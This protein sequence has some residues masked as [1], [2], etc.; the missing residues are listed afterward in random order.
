MSLPKDI[1]DIKDNTAATLVE[2]RKTNELLELIV[3]TFISGSD[4][5]PEVLKSL[6]VRLKAIKETLAAGIETAKPPTHTV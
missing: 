3:E 4:E 6:V 2:Q 1:K 5:D